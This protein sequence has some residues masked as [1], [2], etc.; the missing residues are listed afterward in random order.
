MVE[1]ILDGGCTSDGT[2]TGIAGNQ[3]PVVKLPGENFLTGEYNTDINLLIDRCVVFESAINREICH[4]E[5]ENDISDNQKI[6]LYNLR[7]VVSI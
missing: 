6:T 7:K 1:E 5:S 4:L 2:N 3:D